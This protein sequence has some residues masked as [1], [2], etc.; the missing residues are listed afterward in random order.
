[1]SI[2]ALNNVTLNLGGKCLLDQVSWQIEANERIALLGRNG[3]GKSSLL[4]LVQ[5]QIAVDKGEVNRQNQLVIA[6]LAQEVNEASQTFVYQVLVSALGKKGEIIARF[7]NL[8]EQADMDRLAACQQDMDKFGCWDL[9]PRVE[10]IAERLGVA[11]KARVANLSGGMKRRALLAAALIAEP[12]LLLLD[13]PTNH[14]DL[15]GI[16]WLESYLKNFHGSLLLVT[17]DRRFM[18][19]VANKIVEVDRGQLHRFDCDYETYLDRREAMR[20]AEQKQHAEFDKRLAEEEAWIRQGI[21]ARRTRNEGRVR[22]LKAMR[23]QYGQRLLEPGKIE[24]KSLDTQRSG[25]IVLEA[26]HLSYAVSGKNIINDFSLVLNRGAKIGILGPNGCG[27]TTLIRLLTEQLKPDT[28]TLRHGTSLDISYFDQ[29]RN[30][31]DEKATL[32]DAVADG[33]DFV[34]INGQKQ[35]VAS[36]LKSFLFPADRFNQSV[37][38]L[39]GGERNRLLMAKLFAK[40]VN[41][42]V[43]DEPTNDLDIETLELLEDIL[44]EYKGTLLIISHDR[45]FIKNVVSSVIVYEGNGQFN[46]YVGDY[47]DYLRQ[48]KHLQQQQKQQAAPNVRTEPKKTKK[49]SY[50]E[51]RELAALPEKIEILEQMISERQQRMAESDFYQ[52]D[53]QSIADFHQELAEQEEQLSSCYQR[54]EELENIEK[55]RN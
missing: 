29:L 21:K 7:Y 11:P 22:A 23:E 24:K 40:P 52:Q 31:I 4:K 20:L 43:M 47:D 32:M 50:N 51:Q 1:M 26:S 36:Y 37:S 25:K 8:S 44:L 19:N 6:G 34:E 42:L 54:W 41:L 27:K 9:L 14:L 16:E 12:D 46:E 5:G 53:Q 38:T 49:L 10:M 48:K 28:G 13:E 39:S 2:I 35:H 30:Q 15:E 17:H 55:D 45:D 18:S 33:A 3:A